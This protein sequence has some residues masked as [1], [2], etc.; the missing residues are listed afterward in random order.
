MFRLR[1][2]VRVDADDRG[3]DLDDRLYLPKAL[4]KREPAGAHLLDCAGLH[5]RCDAQ[6]RWT[7]AALAEECGLRWAAAFAERSAEALTEPDDGELPAGA[8]PLWL[9]LGGYD[10]WQRLLAPSRAKPFGRGVAPN[11]TGHEAQP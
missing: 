3:A 5:R 9:V 1:Q 6:D 8:G 4:L 7:I 2:A 10:F 11:S